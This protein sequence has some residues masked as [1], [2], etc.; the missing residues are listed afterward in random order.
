MYKANVLSDV[1]LQKDGLALR[2]QRCWLSLCCGQLI[3]DVRDVGLD[4]R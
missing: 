4:V 2:C 1:H 3:P